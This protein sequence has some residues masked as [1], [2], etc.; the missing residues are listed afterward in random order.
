[1][2]RA[3]HS[4][5]YAALLGLASAGLLTAS[6]D[7]TAERREA[8]AAAGFSRHVLDAL[9]VPY[10][11]DAPAQDV[12]ALFNRCVTTER[13]GNVTFYVYRDAAGAVRATAVPFAGR[14]L[15][16][17]IKGLV[18]LEPDGRTIR[19]ILFYEQEETPGLGGEI[20]TRRFTQQFDGRPI[21]S[22][23]GEP[24]IEVHAISGATM[25]SRRVE[26][27][28]NEAARKIAEARTGDEP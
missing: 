5:V 7:L 11:A 17:P 9:G 22:A 10:D 19:R 28:L 27:M 3:I 26:A 1:M 13:R 18:A 15:W 20:A 4:L 14:G 25:T 8:N 12:V 2:K 24:S 23:A 21:V 16:G 6:R